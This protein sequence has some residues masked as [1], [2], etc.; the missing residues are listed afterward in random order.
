MRSKQI[1]P[2]LIL[3]LFIT[4][5][6]FGQ[7]STLIAKIKENTYSLNLA[8]GQMEG[9]AAKLIKTAIAESEFVLIG[10]QQLL[11]PPLTANS[12]PGKFSRWGSFKSGN[13]HI[14]DALCDGLINGRD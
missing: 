2:T 12:Q 8:K 1:T 13:R 11:F 3:L 6:L 10:E 9:S 4:G 5:G 14:D 7:D